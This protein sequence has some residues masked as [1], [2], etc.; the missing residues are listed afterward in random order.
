MRKSGNLTSKRSKRM[1]MMAWSLKYKTLTNNGAHWSSK[2]KINSSL[3]SR[4]IASTTRKC[5]IITVLLMIL[6]KRSYLSK[7]KDWTSN[8]KLTL[9]TPK[10]QL[11]NWLPRET[12]IWYS[13]IEP[14]G[15][16][17]K[18]MIE[19]INSKHDWCKMKRHRLLLRRWRGRLRRWEMRCKGS[20]A[21]QLTCLLIL[22]KLY[23]RSVTLYLN[24]SI[25]KSK[26]VSKSFKII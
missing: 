17:L 18:K 4:F 12:K 25:S 8:C 22:H 2:S 10:S 23:K 5:R 14:R 19:I 24:S 11:R 3:L 13:L 1:N 7:F 16:S 21:I 26:N 6:I 15:L 9:E 20:T